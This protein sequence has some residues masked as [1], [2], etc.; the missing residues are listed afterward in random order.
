[1]SAIRLR[2]LRRNPQIRNLV[3]ET[4]LRSED[5]ILP[6]FVIDGKDKRGDSS[7]I[8]SSP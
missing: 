4:R 2:R 7:A 6:Y 5:L 1:M 3:A 8:R